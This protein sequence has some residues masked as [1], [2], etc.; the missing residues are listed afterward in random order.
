MVQV[1]GKIDTGASLA[2]R[3]VL[4]RR[5]RGRKWV[6]SRDAQKRIGKASRRSRQRKC[7]APRRRRPEIRVGKRLGSIVENSVGSA[8]ALP[9]VPARVPRQSD[10][11]REIQI[12]AVRIGQ[13]DSRIAT[14]KQSGRGI[15]INAGLLSCYI[16]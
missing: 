3:R 4:R 13:R 15:G 8:N 10:A 9:A 1:E 14:K 12:T 2:E 11:R 16:G 7:A 5:V 6:S